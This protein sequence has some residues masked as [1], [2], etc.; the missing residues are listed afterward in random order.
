MDVSSGSTI[1]AFRRHVTVWRLRVFWAVPLCTLKIIVS[2]KTLAPIFQIWRHIRGNFNFPVDVYV[3]LSKHLKSLTLGEKCEWLRYM[4][5]GKIFPKDIWGSECIDQYFLDLG[6][7]RR[8]VVSFTLRPLYPRG[9]SPRYPLD[10]RPGGRQSWSGQRGEQKILDPI[11]T[12][13]PTP[14]LSSP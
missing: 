4:W 10:R 12:W 3:G 5:K 6:I 1:P 7:S 13:T 11:G 14:R 9:E 8:W 2:S